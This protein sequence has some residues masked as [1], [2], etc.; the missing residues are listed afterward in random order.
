MEKV[1]IKDIALKY[2]IING[3]S[4][5]SNTKLAKEN[6]NNFCKDFAQ[7][8][9]KLAAEN[10]NMRISDRKGQQYVKYESIDSY[11]KIIVNEQSILDTINQVE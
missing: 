1:N 7:Q 6:F 5:H 11:T 2:G 10:A 8:I 9:L 4:F 3:Y